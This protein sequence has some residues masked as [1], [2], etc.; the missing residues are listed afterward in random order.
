MD[1]QN[2]PRYQ[3]IAAKVQA[4][5]PEQR[6]TLM[7]LAD[8]QFASE[9]MRK[10]LQALGLA[11]QKAGREANLD[12]SQQRL[13]FARQQADRGAQMGQAR[14]N[15]AGDQINWERSNDNTAELIGLGNLGL[16]AGIGIGDMYQQAQ[17][18]KRYQDI[19]NTLKDRTQAVRRF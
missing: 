10:E 1:F 6:A 12:L 13:D 4:L 15:M 14:I 2:D 3:R 8:A 11:T 19:I 9:K 7:K 16:S 5:R 17:Q 18:N